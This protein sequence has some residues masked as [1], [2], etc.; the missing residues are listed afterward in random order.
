M[1]PLVL[2]TTS[3]GTD[4]FDVTPTAFNAVSNTTGRVFWVINN[5]M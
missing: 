1:T 2:L 3:V 5:I 4:V